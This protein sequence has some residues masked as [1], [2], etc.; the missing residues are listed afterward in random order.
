M[1][2]LKYLNKQNFI[3]YE[4]NNIT[5]KSNLEIINS[6][7]ILYTK[8][9]S[10]KKRKLNTENKILTEKIRDYLKNKF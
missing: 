7:E 2:S 3:Y 8:I 9:I 10:A 4:Y 1:N 5:N 6:K